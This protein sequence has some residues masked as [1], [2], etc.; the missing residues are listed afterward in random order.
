MRNF[1]K[2]FFTLVGIFIFIF[3]ITDE[4][5]GVGRFACIVMGSIFSL[6]GS[7]MKRKGD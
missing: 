2:T 1:L 5:D 3:C 4:I 7:N 6:I